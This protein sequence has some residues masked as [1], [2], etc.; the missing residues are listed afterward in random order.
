[1]LGLSVYIG[2]CQSRVLQGRRALTCTGRTFH[3]A[4]AQLGR[5]DGGRAGPGMWHLRGLAGTR[6]RLGGDEAALRKIAGQRAAEGIMQRF[7]SSPGWP[8]SVQIRRFGGWTVDTADSVYQLFKDK[9]WVPE[10]LPA[11]LRL[12]MTSEVLP[13]LHHRE[14]AIRLLCE[15]V[16]ERYQN[17]LKGLLDKEKQ[18][19]MIC[20]PTAGTGESRLAQDALPLLQEHV[21]HPEL[22]A[23]LRNSSVA[24]HVTFGGDSKFD[25]WDLENGPEAA[26][27]VRAL[28]SYFGVEIAVLRSLRTI[29]L[30]TALDC[31]L[32]DFRWRRSLAQDSMVAF[33]LAIDDAGQ[34]LLDVDDAKADRDFL[35]FMFNSVGNWMLRPKRS[36]F[37][38]ALITGTPE[39]EI[40]RILSM[41]GD[42]PWARLKRRYTAFCRCT[43]TTLGCRFLFPPAIRRALPCCEL[44]WRSGQMMTR[45]NNCGGPLVVEILSSSPQELVKRGTTANKCFMGNRSA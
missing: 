41:Y 43:A 17:C 15:T 29:A 25:S 6:G 19:Y 11:P 13:K 36:V 32:L 39:E 22:R 28:A 12:V 33:Y 44:A 14:D 2:R 23:L 20:F 34:T 10:Q 35:R 38:I 3:L 30:P 7:Q 26:L 5:E 21:D 8:L 40:Y 42:H 45:C 37:P 16:S 27:S 4:P 1:M 24:V 9:G 31:I 18:P